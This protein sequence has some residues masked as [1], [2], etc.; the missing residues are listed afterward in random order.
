MCTYL[1]HFAANFF[2]NL[3]FVNT[4]LRLRYEWL[5]YLIVCDIKTMFV[6]VTL[7]L[8]YVCISISSAEISIFLFTV[9]GYQQL[10]ACADTP[11]VSV[12]SC[13]KKPIIDQ[14]RAHINKRRRELYHEKKQS[15]DRCDIERKESIKQRSREAYHA[16]KEASQ[17]S[18]EKTKPSKKTCRT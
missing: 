18:G 2:G 9:P 10:T 17:M 4:L 12:K 14:Q 13:K 3:S 7:R 16:K 6:V 8:N 15:T 11:S 1:H 5:H